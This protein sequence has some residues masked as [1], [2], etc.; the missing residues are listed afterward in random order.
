MDNILYLLYLERFWL[1]SPRGFQSHLATHSHL[2]SLT[3]YVKESSL[4]TNLINVVHLNPIPPPKSLR[5]Q[6]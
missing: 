5:Q 3:A 1:T 2:H 4:T 6:T